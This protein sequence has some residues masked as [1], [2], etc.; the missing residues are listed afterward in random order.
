MASGL[1]RGPRV[2]VHGELAKSSNVMRAAAVQNGGLINAVRGPFTAAFIRKHGA[3]GSVSFALQLG[4]AMLAREGSARVEA[5]VRFLQGRILADGPV[6]ENK[7]RYESGF[8]VGTVRIGEVT[9]G[10][11]NELMTAE[12]HGERLASFPDLLA[13]FDPQSG[14]PVAVSALE[15]GTRVAIVHAERHRIPL[16]AGVYDPA[17]YPEVEAAMGIDLASF[18]LT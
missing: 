10:V 13:S 14:A 16:G 7:V 6:L 4:A 9:L 11:Y 15:P 18:A 5:A 1:R 17:V 3:P 12:A 2:L 8:D